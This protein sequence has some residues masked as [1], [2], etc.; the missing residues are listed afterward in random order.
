MQD[1]QREVCGIFREYRILRHFYG[2]TCG[3]DKARS[4]EHLNTAQ[5]GAIQ[6]S[7]NDSTI[8]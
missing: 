8:S 7:R 4:W 2:E 6:T 5:L 1:A 3:D